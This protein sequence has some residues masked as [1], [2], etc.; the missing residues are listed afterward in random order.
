MPQITWYMFARCLHLYVRVC[1]PGHIHWL[2]SACELPVNT[3]RKSCQRQFGYR[4]TKLCLLQQRQGHGVPPG[5]WGTSTRTKV[6]T[7][8]GELEYTG[9]L[10]FWTKTGTI[11]SSVTVSFRVIPKEVLC[12]TIVVTP[13][14]SS[15]TVNPAFLQKTLL[16]NQAGD[17][18]HS[19]L[20]ERLLPGSWQKRAPQTSSRDSGDDD[21]SITK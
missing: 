4:E 2:T 14:V 21:R 12:T 13:F 3:G 16:N 10:P 18:A 11:C 15:S 7:T 17:R 20:R 9:M 6:T 1:G 19:F 8:S 5:T